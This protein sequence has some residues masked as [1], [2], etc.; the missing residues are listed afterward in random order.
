MKFFSIKELELLITGVPDIDVNE[1]KA[2]AQFGGF[3]SQS[4]QVLWLFAMLEELDHEKLGKF[5]QFV[6]GC[7]CLPVDGLKPPLLV[8]LMEEIST[9]ADS[10]LPRSHTCF[11]QIVIPR[12]S[13]LEVMK[14]Q[15]V[16]ALEN[17][18]EGFFI[19]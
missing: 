13:S 11:N 12:Y 18:A 10:T 14:K 4:D 2:N 5:L 3:V 8:T 15:I 7:P 19:S 16:Y 6:S 9:S 17:A 1:L